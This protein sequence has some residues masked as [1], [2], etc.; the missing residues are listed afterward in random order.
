LEMRNKKSDIANNPMVLELLDLG[1]WL[2]RI[3][4]EPLNK[5]DR[6]KSVPK[7][8]CPRGVEPIG[9]VPESLRSFFGHLQSFGRQADRVIEL[10]DTEG[11]IRSH[12]LGD[13]HGHVPRSELKRYELFLKRIVAIRDNY[14]ILQLAFSHSLAQQLGAGPGRLKVCA[15]WQV[16]AEPISEEGPRF[17]GC[18][19]CQIAKLLEEAGYLEMCP[20]VHDPVP[21]IALPPGLRD[22]P[23]IGTLCLGPDIPKV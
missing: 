12:H 2:R 8:R 13:L 23:L 21:A 4:V 10:F 11:F 19:G 1:D 15:D 18:P 16:V 9:V 6:E 3:S 14:V 17:C 5:E 20:E 7:T 22:V